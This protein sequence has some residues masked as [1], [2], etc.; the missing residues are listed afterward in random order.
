VLLKDEALA[1][2]HLDFSDGSDGGQN[3]GSVPGKAGF[4][5]QLQWSL[6]TLFPKYVATHSRIY[7]KHVSRESM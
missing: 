5:L 2:S 1:E 3:L 7:L 4:W 6:I